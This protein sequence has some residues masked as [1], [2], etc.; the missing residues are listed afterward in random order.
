MA[1]T[2]ASRRLLNSYIIRDA[3]KEPLSTGNLGFIGKVSSPA[4]GAKSRM[5]AYMKIMIKFAAFAL[6]L[7]PKAA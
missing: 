2:I 3:I 1:V 7:L 6:L 4:M 5:D